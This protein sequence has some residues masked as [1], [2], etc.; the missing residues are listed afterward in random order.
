M[1]FGQFKYV[2]CCQFSNEELNMH[3]N[4]VQLIAWKFK[5]QRRM[6]AKQYSLGIWFKLA[7]SHLLSLS[8]I[9]TCLPSYIIKARS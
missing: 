3:G 7:T 8:L 2:T 4:Q 9:L 1:S 5:A 6:M